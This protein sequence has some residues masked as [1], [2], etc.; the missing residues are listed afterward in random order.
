M[1]SWKT[2]IARYIVTILASVGFFTSIFLVFITYQN[3]FPGVVSD[4][5]LSHSGQQVVFV[6]MS[7]IAT[8]DFYTQKQA[9]ISALASSGYI[10][11]FE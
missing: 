1:S 3:Q 8:S 2:A 6:Q 5:T 4:I 11:L 10:I 7:H 9:T